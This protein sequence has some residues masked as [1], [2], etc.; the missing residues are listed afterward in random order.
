MQFVAGICINHQPFLFSNV[1]GDSGWQAN[2]DQTLIA[3]RSYHAPSPTGST[4]DQSFSTAN[5]TSSRGS[6][7]FDHRTCTPHRLQQYAIRNTLYAPISN[8]QSPIPNHLIVHC[9]IIHCSFLLP[10][11]LLAPDPQSRICKFREST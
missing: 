6:N 8:L 1:D 4:H 3:K 2:R 9:F 5:L 11:P 7:P 10:F